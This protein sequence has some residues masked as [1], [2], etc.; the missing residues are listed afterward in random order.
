M[1]ERGTYA[2]QV[3]VHPQ[4]T[5]TQPGGVKSLLPK[6]SPSTSQVLAVVTLL[7]VGGT[8]L[9]L[10]GITLVGTLI[11]LA[12]ATPLF[13]LFSPVL[14]PAALTIGLAVTGFLG[15]GAFGLT[16]L[17][18]L[19][20]VLSYFR[21]ASQRVPDQIELAKK[22]AQEMA[23]YAG[24]KTKEVGDTI[25]SKAAQAQDT[26]ATTGRDTRST[27]RDTSRT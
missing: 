10:A 20:W 15:S 9:F 26:T 7:P 14:V 12:V 11:G 5:A 1:A 16:G 19:S 27:A 3:Q 23:A 21:Q 18:S 8:L 17:S 24:Q 2:H 22:R 13:L 4:Q 25:Q 6:N